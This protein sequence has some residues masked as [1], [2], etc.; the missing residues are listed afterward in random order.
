M[1][2]SPRELLEFLKSYEWEGLSRAD[3]A[4]LL[5]VLARAEG[6]LTSRLAADPEVPARRSGEVE[7]DRLLTPDDV[8]SVLKKPRRAIYSLARRADWQSFVVKVNRK[9]LRFRESGLRRWLAKRSTS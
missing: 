9:T 3:S 8:A 7:E 2:P 6:E 5:A 4:A 1:S